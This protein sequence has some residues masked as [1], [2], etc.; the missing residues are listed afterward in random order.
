MTKQMEI[1]P[2]RAAVHAH[3]GQVVELD[4]DSNRWPEFFG[5]SLQ[6]GPARDAVRRNLGLAICKAGA[7]SRRLALSKPR[8]GFHL[9]ARTRFTPLPNFFLAR[10]KFTTENG[11]RRPQSRFPLTIF[12][13]G[14]SRCRLLQSHGVLNN[15][16]RMK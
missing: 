16:K 6:L 15:F 5:M 2:N 11:R 12:E 1:G 13:G 8:C 7:V 14:H 4:G 3:M 9:H 10:A